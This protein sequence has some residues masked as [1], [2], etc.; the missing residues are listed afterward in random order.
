MENTGKGDLHNSYTSKILMCWK[1]LRSKKREGFGKEN[2]HVRFH[3]E[4]WIKQTPS[5]AY[6][7]TQWRIMPKIK[8]ANNVVCECGVRRNDSQRG[9]LT[10]CL[11]QINKT[12][13]PQKRQ[14]LLT[15]RATRS[16]R[17]PL[18]SGVS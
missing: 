1:K 9:Q 2:K 11:K 7:S 4:A 12:Y 10:D 18:S 13:D 17:R 16:L 15:I 6:F 3:S 8:T 5:V 14:I